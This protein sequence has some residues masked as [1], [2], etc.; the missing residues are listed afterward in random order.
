MRQAA[1]RQKEQVSKQVQHVHSPVSTT[2]VPPPRRRNSPRQSSSVPP[3][4][5][6]GSFTPD[7]DKWMQA[8]RAQAPPPKLRALPGSAF[9]PTRTSTRAAGQQRDPSVFSPSP[10]QPVS[11]PVP[12]RGTS[13]KRTVMPDKFQG[14]TPLDEYLVHFELCAE[15]NGWDNMEKAKYLAVCLRGS[16]QCLLGT[17]QGSTLRDYT[18]LVGALRE[19]YGTEGQ[20]EIFMAELQSRQQGPRESFQELADGVQR[21]VGKSYPQATT[22]TL[23]ILSVQ[24]FQRALVDK[25]LRMR[26]KLAKPT[27]IRAAVL[28]AIEYEAIQRSERVVPKVRQVA[29]ADVEVKPV[30]KP[31]VAKPAAKPKVQQVNSQPDGQLAEMMKLLTATLSNLKQAPPSSEQPQ[32]RQRKPLGE[33]QCF[34]CRAMGHFSSRC[35]ADN[36]TAR[37]RQ[38]EYRQSQMDTQS[39]SP[40]P[41]GN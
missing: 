27:T 3:P 4:P 23:R 30:A 39:Q 12:S 2:P 8:M 22:D 20:T 18:A 33:I 15:L 19:R 37:A 36:D 38:A 25:E 1:Q 28:Q 13:S 40:K 17:L 29:E 41:A 35:E 21:L 32:R 24:Y 16:A 7:L 11:G 14:T 10:L 26:I 31:K 34:R 9:E 5:A 6:Y